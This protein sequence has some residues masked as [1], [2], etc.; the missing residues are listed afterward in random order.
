MLLHYWLFTCKPDACACSGLVFHLIATS[1][2]K[3]V[4]HRAIVVVDDAGI[5]AQTDKVLPGRFAMRPDAC[6]MEAGVS[7]AVFSI[8]V[9]TVHG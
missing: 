6:Q 3:I 9:Y 8:D 4:D 1:A 7:C 2:I 5:N